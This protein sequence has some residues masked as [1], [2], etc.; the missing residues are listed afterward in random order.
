MD[1]ISSLSFWQWALVLAV[2]PAIVALYFLKLRRQP[3]EVPSTYLWQKSIED[4]HVN[5]LWQRIRQNLLLYLQL[6]ILALVIFSLLR[7]GWRS[8]DLLGKRHIFMIDNSASMNATDIAPSRLQE[9][10]RQALILIESMASGDSGM[11]I[12]FSD[13]ARV[14]QGFTE[15]TRDLRRAVENIKPTRRTTALDE[16]LRAAVG[17]ANSGGGLV[18]PDLKKDGGEENQVI[19]AQPA[20]LYIFSDGRFPSVQGFSLGALEPKFIPIGD[21]NAPN[22]AVVA[23]SVR[24]NEE[25]ENKLQAFGSIENFGNEAVK[26][27]VELL[28][29][30]NL[31]D[32]SQV[33]VKPGETEGVKFDLGEVDSGILEL[34]IVHPDPLPDDNLAWAAVNS[35]RKPKVLLITP[36]NEALELALATQRAGELAEISK[37]APEVLKTKEHQQAAASGMYDLIIYDRSQPERSP[38]ANTL[39]IGEL[40]PQPVDDKTDVETKNSDNKNAQN[41]EAKSEASSNPKWWQFGESI[42][43]PQIIDLDRAHP[44][45]QWL[46]LGDVDIV[47]ARSVTPPPGGT[48]LIDSNKGT[49]L[50]IAPREGFEDAVMGFDIYGVDKMGERYVNTNWILRRSFPTFVFAVL[51]YLGGNDGAQAGETVKPGHPLALK[52][53]LPVDELQV[54][55]PQGARLTAPRSR[56]GSF[57]FSDTEEL[58]PYKV[59]E[60][61]KTIEQFTVNLFDELESNIRPAKEKSIQI[62]HISVDASPGYEPVR[63]ETWRWLLLA[64]LAVLLLEWYIYNRRVYV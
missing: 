31:I 46:D 14:E 50:A 58:G 52:S 19:E 3:L 27:Q 60:N 32:A 33:A 30:G 5:S 39:Y 11:V 42:D 16:A 38:R 40:P 59:Q 36:G 4:L 61:D 53:D 43:Y 9:A 20:T 26:S 41:S 44:L 34:R 54:L 21:A 18:N 10:K 55:T 24:R 13:V 17:L 63:R 25:R 64:G 22:L 56:T 48:R 29:N 7:P 35:S 12:S 62:G 47:E 1:F 37:A 8:G 6:L 28:L 57:Q 51:G 23:F 2:P 49:I 15:N 45:M